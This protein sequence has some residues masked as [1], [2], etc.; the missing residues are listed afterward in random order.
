MKTDF[1]K[2]SLAI[3]KHV[4]KTNK[5][6]APY[7]QLTH[8]QSKPVAFQNS[9][10]TN[11]TNLVNNQIKKAKNIQEPPISIH[12]MDS[13][14]SDSFSF[15]H[16]SNP[17]SEDTLCDPPSTKGQGISWITATLNSCPPSK[18]PVIKSKSRNPPGNS[19]NI[20]KLIATICETVETIYSLTDN[21]TDVDKTGPIG[22]LQMT[23]WA[24][25]KR[26]AP[27][28]EHTLPK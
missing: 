28:E 22:F 13:H 7:S 4:L 14:I 20:S 1:S 12:S 2:C 19:Q 26:D 6:N 3:K 16:N 11:F 9:S 27:N 23:L 8:V 21:M 15:I 17:L 24:L 10:L 25:I 18:K 5:N